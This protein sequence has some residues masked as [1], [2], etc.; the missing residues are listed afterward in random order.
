MEAKLIY[1]SNLMKKMLLNLEKAISLY[2]HELEKDFLN[3]HEIQERCDAFRGNVVQCLEYSIE[4]FWKY[5]QTYLDLCLGITLTESGPKKIIRT[6][7]LH[8]SITEPEAFDLFEAIKMRNKTSH[9][10]HEEIAD[11]VAKYAPQAL[12]IM[13][14][15]FNRLNAKTT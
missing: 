7:I 1:S 5:I 14:T 4:G 12:K 8:G 13:Q 6:A 10:Y 3:N 15:I 2:H 11:E 9:I